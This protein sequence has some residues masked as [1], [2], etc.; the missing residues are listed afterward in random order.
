MSIIECNAA[1]RRMTTVNSPHDAVNCR[2]SKCSWLPS[3]TLVAGLNHMYIAS[4]R[5]L[6]QYVGLTLAPDYIYN[7]IYNV[8]HSVSVSVQLI[9]RNEKMFLGNWLSR[10]TRSS[11]S[12]K[13]S[14]SKCVIKACSE[15][16]VYLSVRA[17][18]RHQF[19]N[20]IAPFVP[21]L[22]RLYK[23]LLLHVR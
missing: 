8:C 13:T 21:F 12:S 22:L 2:R 17:M 23:S 9:D 1:L 11:T 15:I 19:C 3:S 5:H 4:P 7:N 20:N 14:S 18:Y 16:W 10:I 6:V